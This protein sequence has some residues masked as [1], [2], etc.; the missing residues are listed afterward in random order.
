MAQ[1]IMG[2]ESATMTLE[3]CASLMDDDVR[4]RG[5]WIDAVAFPVR[6]A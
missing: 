1:R 4:A 2:H 3:V 5:S 6:T